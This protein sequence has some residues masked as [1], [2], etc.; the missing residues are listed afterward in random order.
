MK[1]ILCVVVSLMLLLGMMGVASAEAPLELTLWV[2]EA[3]TEIFNYGAE[4]YNQAH[5]DA[6]ISLNMEFYP[7][8]EMH[9]KLL[10]AL[11]SGV[12]APDIVDIN[13]TWFA[14]FVQEDCQLV[15]LNDIVEPVLDHVVT[16]RFDLYAVNGNY[17]GIPTHVGAT[18]MYYNT[19]L[20]EAAGITMDEVNA[21]T[22]WDQY[23]EL[24]R[25][26]KAAMG[27]DK[28]WTA[29][30]TMNQRPFWPLMNSI[31]TDYINEDGE[32]IM[33]CPENI[34]LLEW[35]YSVFQEGIAVA[36]PGG[37]L[38]NESFYQWMNGGNCASVLMPSWYMS[39][40]IDFMPDLAG[41]IAMRPV[42]VF[43]EGQAHS[44]AVGGTPTCITNQCVDVDVA[45]EFLALAKLS[46][47]G[48]INIWKSCAFDPVNLNV[49]NSPE[50]AEHNDYFQDSF[51]EVMLPYADNIP[52]PVQ[53]SNP[54]S[55]AAQQLVRNNVMYDVF[56]TGAKTPAQALTDAA[57]EVRNSGK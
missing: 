25:K 28:A 15:P 31:G 24:G 57:N 33:D 4:L 37:D 52:S 3:H 53:P 10:I 43:E 49:W 13:I 2:N 30:E 41:K 5:P 35:M 56:V 7:V 8:S 55:A 29:Y 45:K 18:V 48:S 27:D 42:P 44:T 51:F 14:N 17:Y 21:V 20:I 40:L 16:S 32:V 38:I 54:R 47:E 11:Q 39:R 23:L 50:L 36:A 34:A 6:P 46:D 19:E 1:R 22:T 26:F 9:N 12:G